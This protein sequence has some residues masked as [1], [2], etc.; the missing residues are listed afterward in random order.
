MDD[1]GVHQG[2]AMQRQPQFKD[3][4]MGSVEIAGHAVQTRNGT[5]GGRVEHGC[6]GCALGPGDDGSGGVHFADAL[7]RPPS[8]WRLLGSAR[9][10][11][12]WGFEI[13]LKPKAANLTED[14][15]SER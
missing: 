14:S 13:V 15:V 7:A 8:S 5:V 10:D 1:D 9:S 6:S 11:L 4:L 12:P 2:K 3:G